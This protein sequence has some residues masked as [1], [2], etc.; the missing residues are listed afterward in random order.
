LDLY[1]RVLKSVPGHF[2]SIYR[3]GLIQLQQRQFDGAERMFRKAI[4]VD[5]ASADAQHHLAVTLTGLGRQ[6]TAIVHYQKALALN[7][8]YAEAHNNFAHT[9]QLLGHHEEAV[10]HCEHALA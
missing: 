9:L 5:E 2:D 1:N 8:R 10:V 6:E 4:E 7:P 3:L